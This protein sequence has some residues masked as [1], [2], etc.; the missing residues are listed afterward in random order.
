MSLCRPTTTQIAS[1]GWSPI[2][3]R[4]RRIERYRH[5]RAELVLVESDS[6]SEASARDVAVLVGCTNSGRLSVRVPAR[7]VEVGVASEFPSSGGCSWPSRWCT[8][9]PAVY[10]SW[11]CCSGAASARRNWRSSCCV[12]S[13]RSCGGRRGG[14][15]HAGGPA[16]SHGAQPDAAASL[17]AGVLGEAGDAFALASTARRRPLD[18]PA[19]ASRPAA[20]RRRGA[21][22]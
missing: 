7:S 11:S 19:P 3:Q 9:L 13:C 17:V 2:A 10:S 14:R 21:R 20:D 4:R 1:A 18:L 6:H 8:S 5:S 16:G 22:A 15:S 12:T